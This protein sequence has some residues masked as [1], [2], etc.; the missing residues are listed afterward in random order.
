MGYHQVEKMDCRAKGEVI[1]CPMSPLLSQS[2]KITGPIN[3]RIGVD[4]KKKGGRL[5]NHSS[6]RTANCLDR[7]KGKMIVENSL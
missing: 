2:P 4:R 7:D 1:F 6:Q 3:Q 5:S